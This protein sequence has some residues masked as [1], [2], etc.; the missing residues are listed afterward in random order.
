MNSIN[1]EKLSAGTIFGDPDNDEYLY[2][3]GAEIGSPFP[4]CIFQQHGL[5][6]DISL[7]EAAELIDRLHLKAL[8]LPPFSKI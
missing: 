5:S 3:P 6:E 1:K 2:M 4:V 7:E 8:D